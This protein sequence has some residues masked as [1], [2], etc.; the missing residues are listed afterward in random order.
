MSVARSSG[1]TRLAASSNAPGAR[2]FLPAELHHLV[3]S[4]DPGVVRIGI[5]RDDAFEPRHAKRPLDELGSLRH[6]KPRARV[7]GVEAEL[8]VGERWV[9][10]H[11]RR[12][13]VHRRLVGDEVRRVVACDQ[14]RE[15]PRLEAESP[16]AP[17]QVADALTERVPRPGLPAA[18]PGILPALGAPPPERGSVREPC[19]GRRERT[20]ERLPADGALDA[21]ALGLDVPFRVPP[22]HEAP[23]VR[24]A[25]TPQTGR[26]EVSTTRLGAGKREK[27]QAPPGA[28]P[29]SAG[30]RREPEGPSPRPR[31]PRRAASPGR[32]RAARPAAKGSPG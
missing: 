32:P 16:Q 25:G 8:L 31:R 5:D 30:W 12:P 17:G 20:H 3:P 26:S 18:G 15:V 19:D 9:D 13:E 10:A 14:E 2:R 6:R 28:P 11:R 23:T 1:R 4:D 24:R 21:R 22:V 29:R 27:A 7:S